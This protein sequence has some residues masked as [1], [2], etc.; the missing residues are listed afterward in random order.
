VLPVSA[1]SQRLGDARAAF[2]RPELSASHLLIGVDSGM[3]RGNKIGLWA[4]GGAVVGFAVGAS[5]ADE[6]ECQD[7]CLSPRAG[8]F[9]FGTLGAGIGGL[10]GALIGSIV[11][12]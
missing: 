2:V 6:D 10:L 7:Y 9:L 4:L 8:M 12:R 1:Q 3:S 5:V 11:T